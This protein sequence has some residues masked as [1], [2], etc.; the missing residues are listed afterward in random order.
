MDGNL[1]LPRQKVL[2][3]ILFNFQIYTILTLLFCVYTF[4]KL[5]VR[6]HFPFNFSLYG[7]VNSLLYIL[8]YAVYTHTT[9]RFPKS[10]TQLHW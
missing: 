7:W 1:L 3:A 5:R 4:L 2:C 10:H 8:H 6:L 9:G